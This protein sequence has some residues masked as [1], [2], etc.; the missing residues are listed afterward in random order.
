MVWRK[1]G[2]LFCANNNSS[3][4]RTGGRTPVAL[5]LKNDIFKIFFGSYD[6][7]LRGKIY[8][9]ELDLRFPEKIYNLVT[10]PII[11]K[12]DIGFYDD[13]GIIPSSILVHANKVYLYTIG[14]SL[15]IKLFLM[16]LQDLQ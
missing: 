11:D 2:K 6:E 9:L 16:H 4:M 5:H 8:S 1:I 15:K 13:N 7:K 10:K 12:G 14:F 3:F